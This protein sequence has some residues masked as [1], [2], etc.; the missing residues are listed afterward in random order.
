M[1]PAS[2]YRRLRESIRNELGNT[3]ACETEAPESTTYVKT[4]KSGAPAHVT[5]LKENHE[6][7]CKLLE[8]PCCMEIKSGSYIECE[9][10][11]SICSSCLLR[12]MFTQAS[13][14]AGGSTFPQES[15]NAHGGTV[16]CPTCKIPMDFGRRSR[17]LESL[18]STVQ[19]CTCEHTGCPAGKG[20]G[21]GSTGLGAYMTKIEADQHSEICEFRRV[22]CPFRPNSYMCENRCND[23]YVPGNLLDH[24]SKFHS[25]KPADLDCTRDTSNISNCTMSERFMGSIGSRQVR[26]GCGVSSIVLDVLFATPTNVLDFKCGRQAR[27]FVTQYKGVMY[28]IYVSYIDQNVCITVRGDFPLSVKDTPALR[29]CTL[30][31]RQCAG[32]LWV[33]HQSKLIKNCASF[34]SLIEHETPTRLDIP[35]CGL[36]Q[37]TPYSTSTGHVVSVSNEEFVKDFCNPCNDS[38]C[39][40]AA[41]FQVR[42]EFPEQM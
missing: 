23:T 28:T 31:P 41:H 18:V 40:C 20:S 19:A 35:Q 36:R 22:P 26:K 21:H 37:D 38:T 16:P 24:I 8:C 5:I 6:L 9:N 32:S 15:G 27:L 10:G 33:E 7:M 29:V 1:Q 11:H 39:K 30:F 34:T 42:I 25:A 14:N 17:L 4:P 12:M 2:K 3:G 13:G